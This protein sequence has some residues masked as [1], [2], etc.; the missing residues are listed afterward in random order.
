MESSTGNFYSG[1][2]SIWSELGVVGYMLYM[3]LYI[4]LIIHVVSK[5]RRNQYTEPVQ[6]VLAEGF[7]MA[8]LLFLMVSFIA[9]IFWAKYF[10]GALWIWAAMVWD[11][12]APERKKTESGESEVGG[13]QSAVR[14][15]NVGGR[16]PSP[17]V[18]GWRRPPL[19]K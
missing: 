7:V 9:D 8:G 12:V 1:I 5:L 6:L 14:G 13:Q 10:A 18:N 11:P 15:R 17:A 19:R 3:G 2:L 4:S 16:Q